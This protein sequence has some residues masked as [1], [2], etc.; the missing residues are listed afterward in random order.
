MIPTRAFGRAIPR[1]L[2]PRRAGRLGL[3]ASN[4][5]RAP[6]F[7]VR[8][9]QFRFPGEARGLARVIAGEMRFV[10]ALGGPL[11]SPGRIAEDLLQ[12]R[13]PA[14]G[15]RPSAPARVFT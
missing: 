4:V 1:S 3:A 7:P 15:R 12:Q 13:S 14:R 2:C 11:V 10:R 9:E 5:G 6:Q 8:L